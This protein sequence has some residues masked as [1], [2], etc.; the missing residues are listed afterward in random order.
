MSAPQQEQSAA[1]GTQEATAE[2]LQKIL[3]R[4]IESTGAETED[5]K[6][7]VRDWF[8]EFLGH[9]V[10]PD[11]VVS[12]EVEDNIE[13]WI[14]EIDKKLSS[15]LNEVLHHPDFQKLEGTWRGLNYF[16]DQTFTNIMLK[17]RVLNVTQRELFKDLTRTNDFTRTELWKKVYEDEYGTLGGHP[18]GMM[19]ADYE[20]SNHPEDV[21][22]LQKLAGVAAGAHAPMVAGTSSKMFGFKSFT[23][24]P[25]VMGDVEKIFEGAD[26]IDWRAFRESEDSRYVALAMPHVLGRL[27]YG[28]RGTTV[29]EFNYEEDVDGKDHSKY[30][31]MNAAWAYAARVTDAYFN[32]GW[33]LKTRGVM[34]GGKVEGLPVSTFETDEGKVAV[35]CPSEI[36]I[37]E[38]REFELSN[39]GFLPLI[40]CKNSDYAVFMG[41]QSCQKPKKYNTIEANANAEISTKFNYLLCVSR[42]AHYLKVMARDRIGSPMTAPKFETWLNRWIMDYVTDPNTTGDEGLAKRPLTNARVEVHEVPGKPGWFEATAWL[43]PHQQFEALTASMRLVAQIPAKGQ[44]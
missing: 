40:Y 4:V 2:D 18:I 6:K 38:R 25:S 44:G 21:K 15:Q 16:V 32:H 33:F 5:Q 1:A 20:F 35:K 34:Y 7:R 30:L 19:V 27:P 24:L 17:I 13:Y 14:A 22:L 28:R 8:G 12:R 39:L 3:D 37:T 42:F 43:Q 11:Q 41:S 36:G 31:W 9:I 26:Y 10:K 29:D 23:Q